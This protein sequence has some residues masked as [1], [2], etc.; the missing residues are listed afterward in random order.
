MTDNYHKEGGSKMDDLNRS[1]RSEVDGEDNDSVVVKDR[2]RDEEKVGTCAKIFTNKN[3]FNLYGLVDIGIWITS[4]V[5]IAK[6][7]NKMSHEFYWL[8]FFIYLP[9]AIL[10]IIN[11]FASGHRSL[12]V[13]S[14]W[15]RLKLLLQGFIL[16]LAAIQFDEL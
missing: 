8:A 6:A 4:I 2:I 1:S 3:I 12:G 15:L 9:N 11:A 5:F 14:S 16:P 7:K 10:F 13:Y